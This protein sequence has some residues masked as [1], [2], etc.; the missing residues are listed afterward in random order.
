MIWDIAIIEPS[1]FFEY[2]ALKGYNKEEYNQWFCVAI[3][4]VERGSYK[5]TYMTVGK[6]F[7]RK[8]FVV[9]LRVIPNPIPNTGTLPPTQLQILPTSHQH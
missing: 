8:V 1:K 4:V 2:N 9:E 5:L 6:N 3:V 7:G